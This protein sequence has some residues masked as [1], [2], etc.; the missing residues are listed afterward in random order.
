[1]KVL[2][3]IVAY[4][5]RQWID[6]C[7]GSLRQSTFPV[8]VLVID[9]ASSD[10][11]IQVIRKQYPEARIIT[12][13][14]NLGFGQANNIGIQIALKENYD[15]VLLLNQDAWI[16]SQVIANLVETS[17]AH[18]EYGILSPVHLSG[19]HSKIEQGFANYIGISKLEK[20]PI[21]NP[22][23]VPFIDAAIWFI[24]TNVFKKVGGFSPLFYHYG[25]D[26][27]FVNRLKYNKYCIGY[28]PDIFGCHDREFRKITRKDFFHSEEVYLLSEYANI[29]Y[30]FLKAF[31][32]CILAGFKKS[33]IALLQ[34]KLYDFATFQ[35]ISYH[36]LLKT[37][38]V[39]NI[40]KESYHKN[41]NFI[42]S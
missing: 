29:N 12:N 30:S 22:V 21:K 42:H 28:L 31:G 10:D 7:L 23:T 25:E 4:N 19:D 11:T 40:R 39:C 38:E 2:V 8:D 24:P 37:F 36:L 35:K 1:M 20:L 3:I 15:F 26:K 9:N 34:G 5:F 41:A 18:S 14:K 27:D 13:K 17:R 33:Y 32:Y 6:R 16:D